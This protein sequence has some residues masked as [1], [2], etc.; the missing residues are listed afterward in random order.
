MGDLNQ[1]RMDVTETPNPYQSP[2]I[3]EVHDTWWAKV[4]RLFTSPTL[5]P[6][7]RFEDGDKVITGGIAFYLDLEDSSRLLAAS[8]SS[9]ETDERLNLVVAEAIRAFPLFLRNN[10]SLLPIVRGRKLSV[11]LIQAYSDDPSV[12]IREYTLHWD[13]VAGVID[14]TPGEQ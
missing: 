2:R 7:V 13:Y 11:R 5:A 3:T 4:C 14:D 9:V 12:F 10:P 1:D 6:R 8:P